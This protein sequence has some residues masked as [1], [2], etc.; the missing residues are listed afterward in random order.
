MKT[1]RILLD[2]HTFD[3]GAQGTS[4]CIAGVVNNLV[5]CAARRGIS[6]ELHCAAARKSS[7]DRFV[8]APYT[9][10]PISG[11]FIA[12]NLYAIPALSFR[13]KSHFVISQYVRPLLAHG[14]T[15]AVIHDVLFIDFPR[16]FGR[17]YRWVRTA[18]FFLSARGAAHVVTVSEY[19]RQR[20]A[21]CFGLPAEQILV[22]PNGAAGPDA[23]RIATGRPE[24]LRLLSVSRLER[25]K[26]HEWCIH[27][28]EDLRAQGIDASLTIVGGGAGSYPEHVRSEAERV[29]AAAPGS[30]TFAE[31]LSDAVLDDAYRSADIFLFPSEAEGFGIPVIEAAARGVP[32]V[33]ADNTA[34]TELSRI[35]AGRRFDTRS[36]PAF[37]EA[38]LKIVAAYPS[39]ERDA[40][41]L[42]P[43]V[44]PAFN[45]AHSTQIL[46]DN[47]FVG[48]YQPA[49]TTASEQ[50]S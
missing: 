2:C 12:R 42:A 20:I 16:L 39:V 36:Y 29:N 23:T 21:R 18:L 10:H 4:S 6:I 17:F 14:E 13:I 48:A 47:L 11:G 46:V 1:Y 7:V 50:P 19:S 26:R 40:I 28:V 31:G 8:S 43:Y 32:C 37:L 45:W 34:L 44:A 33:V 25:R 22:V 41:A 9:F 5:A 38:I 3:V 24:R 27:A 35:Y 30:V 15:V 49:A